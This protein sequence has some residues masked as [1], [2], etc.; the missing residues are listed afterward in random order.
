[1]KSGN[2]QT[3]VLFDI[4]GVLLK[5]DFSTFYE[6][7]AD[8]SNRTPEEFKQVYLPLWSDAV[9]GRVDERRHMAELEKLIGKKMPEGKLIEIIKL[10]WPGQIDDVVKLKRKAYQ[11]GYAV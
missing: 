4:G 1:M 3:L 7:C 6:K 11:N 10:L 5:T 8:L 2:R 9:R